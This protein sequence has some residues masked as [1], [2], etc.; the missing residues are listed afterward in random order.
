ME[1]L[2]VI[3]DT[4]DS[5]RAALSEHFI[6]HHDVAIDDPVLDNCRYVLTNGHDGLAREYMDAMPK[7]ALISNYGVGYDAIDAAYA[8]QKSIMVTH[9]PNVLNAEVATTAV[10]LMLASLRELSA[11]ETHVRSACWQEQGNA[12]LSRSA[13]GRTIG[14]VGMGR[15]GQAIAAKLAP[16][17]PRLLY[18]ARSDKALPFEYFADLVAMA[19]EAE[20]LIVI[21][22]GGAATQHLVSREVIEALGP[23]G[24][25]IN[26]ARG[27]VVDE[28][29]MIEALEDGR[30]G[31]AAL[32]VFEQEPHVPQRLLDLPNTVL[33]PHIGSATVETRAAMGQ[34]AVE[35]L[36]LHSRGEK[37]LTPVP[38]CQ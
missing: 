20:I 5:M 4:T 16:F 18:H 11:N 14:I 3:G 9:T 15:I 19:K 26:V 27:S 8:A 33:T 36:L 6:L 12:P 17:D 21:T 37:V 35:N 13:D 34:L 30:L 25:L 1:T 7:L 29:A 22:P 10:M 31:A 32:D 23:E 28:G 24:L 38:E 2:F